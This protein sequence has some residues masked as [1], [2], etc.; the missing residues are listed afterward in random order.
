MPNLTWLGLSHNNTAQISERGRKAVQDAV[1]EITKL[2]ADSTSEEE[3]NTLLHVKLNLCR[4]GNSIG[5]TM[6]EIMD[7][8]R[9]P[10]VVVTA[11]QVD[12][13][14]RFT[15]WWVE[16]DG[17]HTD[18]NLLLFDVLRDFLMTRQ[19]RA[20]LESAFDE[21]WIRSVLIE[22]FDTPK[23]LRRNQLKKFTYN[24]YS[25]CKTLRDA[26]NDAM[27]RA[28]QAHVEKDRGGSGSDAT[29]EGGAGAIVEDDNQDDSGDCY[30][31]EILEILEAI[32]KGYKPSNLELWEKHC[33]EI[34]ERTLLPLH[35]SSHLADF[36]EPLFRCTRE[37]LK[38]DP[39]RVAPMAFD[40]LSEVLRARGKG[41]D[42]SGMLLEEARNI[43][44]VAGD[45][46]GDEGL[47][48]RVDGIFG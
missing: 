24:L 38:K 8:L 45:H 19:D 7:H 18:K 37:F 27:L 36:H 14:V 40:A 16:L 31:V 12:H 4:S 6:T 44:T 34:L 28:L 47:L 48:S 5:K 17:L 42:C 20:V 41:G 1:S 25:H 21:M 35:G 23:A 26:I 9:S 10:D 46:A 11:K 43:A 15:H 3:S 22:A 32:S 13:I 2:L 30:F 29:G 33:S 39:T